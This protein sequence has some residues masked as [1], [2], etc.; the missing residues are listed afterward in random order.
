M[1]FN[2]IPFLVTI[3]HQIK[4]VKAE[5]LHRT[6]CKNIV[7]AII[8]V[9]ECM[10]PQSTRINRSDGISKMLKGLLEQ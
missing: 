10:H 6:I 8:N 2:N 9:V 4:F 7:R 3:S 1:H 5:F